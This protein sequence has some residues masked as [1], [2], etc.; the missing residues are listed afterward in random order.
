M[1]REELAKLGKPDPG[2]MPQGPSNVSF[3]AENPDEYWE[4]IA[5]HVLHET[6]I[7]ARWS[8]K[9]GTHSP[10]RHH[11]DPSTLR[12]TGAY[13]VYTP[14]QLIDE[15]RDMDKAQ[16]I[17]FHPLCGG[18]HPDLAWRSLNLWSGEVLPALREEG[19][20]P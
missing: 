6:N 15:A 9:A 3:V 12:E 7:Y 4:Q 20:A 2:P 19:L 13:K 18:I 14:Q 10:Y 5:P 17:Q 16:P 8:Q 1:Y 11:D